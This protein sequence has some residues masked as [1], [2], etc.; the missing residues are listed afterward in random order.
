MASDVQAC[1]DCDLELP[2]SAAVAAAVCEKIIFCKGAKFSQISQARY[3]PFKIGA[4]VFIAAEKHFA[5]LMIPSA[6]VRGA[7]FKTTRLTSS[8]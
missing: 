6:I 1:L 4:C 7:L 2:R 5:F 3:E 8:V